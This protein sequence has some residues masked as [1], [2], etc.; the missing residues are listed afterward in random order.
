VLTVALQP[1][2]IAA[3]VFSDMAVPAD[4]RA[5][6]MT[7]LFR[8]ELTSGACGVVVGFIFDTLSD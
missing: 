4:A 6:L 2:S 8:T 7:L 3:V 5:T 1:F